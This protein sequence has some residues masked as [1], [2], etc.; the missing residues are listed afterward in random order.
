MG[1]VWRYTRKTWSQAQ[2]D[3]GVR[4][5]NAANA[6]LRERPERG[7]HCDEINAGRTGFRANG[8]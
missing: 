4:K 2:T 8:M 1:D 5:L 7:R 6:E 3:R